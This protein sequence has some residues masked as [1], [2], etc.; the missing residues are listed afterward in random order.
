[1]VKVQVIEFTLSDQSR[2]F[3][4]MLTEGP[5]QVKIECA[6]EDA[7]LRLRDVLADEKQYQNVEISY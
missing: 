4:V 6:D 7:A 2:V 1:M 3:E 5:L